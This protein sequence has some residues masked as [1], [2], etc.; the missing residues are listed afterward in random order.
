MKR[1][2]ERSLVLDRK[3]K[4]RVALLLS[5]Q[6]W[7]RARG[8]DDGGRISICFSSTCHLSM[9]VCARASFSGRGQR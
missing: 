3:K 4:G 2:K 6:V 5:D 7:L 8:Y 1:V 9:L